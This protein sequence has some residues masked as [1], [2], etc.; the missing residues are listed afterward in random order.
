[1]TYDVFG[2]TL[3]LAQSIQ[4]FLLSSGH[5]GRHNFVHYVC[6]T[7]DWTIYFVKLVYK[8][9]HGNALVQCRF[10]N[11]TYMHLSAFEDS[12]VAMCEVKFCVTWNCNSKDYNHSVGEVYNYMCHLQYTIA[13]YL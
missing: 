13:S 8:N 9:L 5:D 7:E 3:N 4:I 2:G 11:D 1:M 10:N 12:L 6:G